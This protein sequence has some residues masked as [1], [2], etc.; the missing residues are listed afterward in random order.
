MAKLILALGEQSKQL[1]EHQHPLL[2]SGTINVGVIKG[3]VQVNFVPDECSIEIDRRLLPGEEAADVHAAYGR[4]F[5]SLGLEAWQDETPLLADEALDTPPDKE[6]VKTASKVLAQMGLPAEPCG[7]P[8]GSDASKL[9]RKGVPSI[10]FGP[11]S[12]DQAHA[13]VE[14]VDCDQVVSA[15]EFY[16]RF[17]MQF[18]A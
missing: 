12:I 7:V 13:A 16:R 4:Y 3:G 15:A 1:L 9:A 2:G 6:V 8:Y 14:W 18:H 5:E 11:G 17:L 10:I